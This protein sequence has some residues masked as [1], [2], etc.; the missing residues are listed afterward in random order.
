MRNAFADEIVK[1]AK[2]DERFLLLV[3]DIGNRLFNPYKEQFLDRFFNCGIAETN[4]LSVAAGLALEGHR[5][6]AYTITPFITTRCIEQIRVDICYHKAPVVIVGV[7]AGLSYANNGPTHHSLEDIALLRALPDMCVLCPADAIEVREALREAVNYNGP[8]YLRLGKKNEPVIH[9]EPFNF[10]IGQPL[11]IQ[12]GS[13][14]CILSTG[15]ILPVALDAAKTLT[16][17]G[18]SVHVESVHTVKPRN[19]DFLSKIFASYSHVVTIEEH[20]KIGGF[21]ASVAEWLCEQRDVKG[22]L[23]ILGTPD[24][25]LHKAGSQDFARDVFGLSPEKVVKSILS[26]YEN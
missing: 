5:P 18:I 15:N 9:K 25:F 8:V 13:D 7:G 22:R 2:D 10:S 17:K 3:G 21:G 23:C 6:V 14:I 16:N 20:G 26:F 4:M 11:T 1:I 24:K 19:E 12:N